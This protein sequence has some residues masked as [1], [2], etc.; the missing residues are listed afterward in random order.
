M[1][2]NSFPLACRPPLALLSPF[3]PLFSPPNHQEIVEKI[4][5]LE[6]G[7]SMERGWQGWLTRSVLVRGEQADATGKTE[8]RKTVCGFTLGDCVYVY[9]SL[10]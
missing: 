10:W 5:S 8:P 3:L 6:P 4:C 7:R 9:I 1:V 2:I